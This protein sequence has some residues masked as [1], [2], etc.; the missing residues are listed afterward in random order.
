MHKTEVPQQDGGW[1]DTLSPR[2][3][4][5]STHAATLVVVSPEFFQTLSIPVFL[6]GR[7]Y[8]S[9]D[10]HHPRVAIVDSN[11]AQRLEGEREVLRRPPRFGVQAE[12]PI[13]KSGAR[14]TYGTEEDRR[15]G[16]RIHHP[17]Y[18]SARKQQ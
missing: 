16:A 15:K 9:D 1:K 14:R 7:S 17:R 2:A 11:F 8:W 18:H 13:P 3:S 10:E 12:H 6:E 4:R 5:D